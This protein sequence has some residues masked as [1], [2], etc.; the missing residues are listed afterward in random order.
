[1]TVV[2]RLSETIRIGVYASLALARRDCS[3]PA[4]SIRAVQIAVTLRYFCCRTWEQTAPRFSL[5]F[6][7]VSSSTRDT[8]GGVEEE[9]SAESRVWGCP[10]HCRLCARRSGGCNQRRRDVPDVDLSFVSRFLEKGP[11]E[12]TSSCKGAVHGI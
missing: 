2:S 6:C 11:V 8:S 1:M 5:D 4:Y 10:S 9:L 7:F 12:R 3:W